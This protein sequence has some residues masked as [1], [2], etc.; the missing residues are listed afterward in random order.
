MCATVIVCPVCVCRVAVEASDDSKAKLVEEIFDSMHVIKESV[1]RTAPEEIDK[2]L[3][4]PQV[5][6]VGTHHGSDAP[7][8]SNWREVA[9]DRLKRK[10]NGNDSALQF[11][12]QRRV[13]RRSLVHVD[14]TDKD[15]NST[16]SNPLPSVFSEVDFP[17]E[18]SWMEA[19][20][21]LGGI[22]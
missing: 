11:D 16:L 17:M 13:A 4:K 7:K 21:I 18:F 15:E 10:L 3:L 9:N 1:P 20:M 19:Y 12:A 2:G 22:L 8:A 14:V 5:V 6:L